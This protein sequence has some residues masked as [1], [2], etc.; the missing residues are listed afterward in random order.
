MARKPNEKL[1]ETADDL[2]G[3]TKAAIVLL[4]VGSERAGRMLQAMEP[5]AVEEVTRELAGWGGCRTELQAEVIEEF[6][7][8]TIASQYA[9]RGQPGLR[10]ADPAE[11]DGWKISGSDVAADPDAGAE[12]AVLVPAAGG[13]REPADVH[14]GRASADDRADPVPPAAPQGRGDPGRAAHAEAGRGD[15][16]GGE[17]GAD[18]PGGDPG[19][20]A[21]AGEPSFEHAGAEHGE[22]RRR[23]DGRGDPEPGGSCERRRRSWRAWRPR[24]RTWWSRSGA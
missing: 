16:A 24:T 15:Q 11:L 10:E 13:E 18:Q 17:H 1:P 12:D 21:R 3:L 19:G 20:G 23:G 22:G 2:P 14:P 4:T 5:Q 8:L 7:N 9:E 6:Y